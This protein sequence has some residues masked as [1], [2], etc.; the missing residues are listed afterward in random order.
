MKAQ[1][2]RLIKIWHPDT[3]IN[4]FTRF[5]YEEMSKAINAAFDNNDAATLYAIER[6]GQSYREHLPPLPEP[7]TAEQQARAEKW[8]H[9]MRAWAAYNNRSTFAKV[10]GVVFD[11]Q[12][13][14]PYLMHEAW[15][16]GWDYHG[17]GKN[18][19]ALITS[20]AWTAILYWLHLQM[21][22][23][24]RWIIAIFPAHAEGLHVSFFAVQVIAFLA[25]LPFVLPLS[26]ILLSLASMLSIVYLLFLGLHSALAWCH[27]WLGPL[28]Y[29]PAVAAALFFLMRTVTPGR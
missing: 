19:H 4:E 2:I 16:D 7:P 3:T 18:T 29:A 17:A 21:P 10:C 23:I 6:H 24:E 5:E 1:H 15:A 25:A 28:A 12:N 27:P 20:S 11:P 22:G 9:H 26:L 13:Y 14:N 8:G